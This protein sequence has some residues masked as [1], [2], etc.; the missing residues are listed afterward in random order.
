LALPRTDDNG[1]PF[2]VGKA[3]EIL[4]FML[5]ALSDV[6][7]KPHPMSR[8]LVDLEQPVL[9]RS[10]NHQRLRFF[11]PPPCHGTPPEFLQQLQKCDLP[12]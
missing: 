1:A 6:I 12:R 7:D 3:E 9:R 5:S 2:A 10:G 4:S 11:E 8:L